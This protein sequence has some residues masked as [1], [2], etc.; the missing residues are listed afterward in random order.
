VLNYTVETSERP[1]GKTPGHTVRLASELHTS[2][3]ALAAA[4]DRTFSDVVRDALSDALETAEV[5]HR[6]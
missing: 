2:V 1:R 6:A 4:T 5:V 3:M